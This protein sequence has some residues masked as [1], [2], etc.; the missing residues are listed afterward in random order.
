VCSIIHDESDEK[1]VKMRDRG[2]DREG[3]GFR[4]YRGGDREEEAMGRRRRGE[5]TNYRT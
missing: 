4:G 1:T 2:G 5:G 3:L